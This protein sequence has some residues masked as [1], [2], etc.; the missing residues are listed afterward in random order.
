MDL[1]IKNENAKQLFAKFLP[2]VWLGLFALAVWL[3]G[4][5][6]GGFHLDELDDAL[7]RIGPW[8]L[9][10]ALLLTAASLFCNA[11]LD[12]VALRWLRKDLPTGKVLGT[13]LIAGSFSM[14]GGGTILGGGA[15]RMRFYG[16]FGLGGAEI[17]KITGF[18]MVAGWLGHALLA[19]IMMCWAPPE[20]D[21]L[22]V[23]AGRAIGVALLGTCATICLLSVTGFRGKPVRFLPPWRVMFVA[24][25]V[26]GFDWLFAGLALRVFLPAA[27]S[28]PAFLAATAVGQALGAAS[29]VPGGVGVM[30]LFI[31]KFS[32]GMV[33]QPLMVGAL[34]TYRLTY[35]FI[36]FVIAVAAVSGREIWAKRHWA[37]ITVDSSG[38]AWSAIAP[39]L[40]GMSALAGGFVLM[41][42]A[43][44]PINANRRILL[45]KFVPLPFVETSH[46][47]SSIA[48]T[49]MII[50]AS[51]LLRRVRAA[52]WI[53]VVMA[54]G[55]ILFS[56][57]KGFDWEESIVLFVF[58][59]ALLPFKSKFHR[60]AGI[61]TR[62]FSLHW[63][64][65]I[66]AIVGLAIWFGFYTSRDV[67]YQNQLWWRYSFENDASRLL[68]G[69][70]GSAM[71][72]VFVALLQ[73][74][75]PA[76]PRAREPQPGIDRI[77]EMVLK[78]S[79]CSSALALV[80]DK[81]FLFNHERSA[82]LMY[83]DQGRTRVA[84]ADPVGDEEKFEGLYWRFVEQA[85]DE[86][87]RVAFYQVG[88]AM[89][90]AC[91]EMGLRIYKLGEEAM[92][93][94]DTF[95]LASSELK[96]F[97]KVMNR[98]ERER[99]LFE[100][101][102]P[103]VVAARLGELRAVSDAWLSH[104]SAREKGFSL[105]CFA[106]AYLRRLPVAVIVVEG[107]VIA[108]GNIWP[109]NG[110]DELSTDLM[111]HVPDAPNGVMDCLFVSMMLWGKAQ[112]YRWFDLGMA[113]LSGLTD[114]PFAPLWSRIGG[115][116]YDK[117]EAFYNF[118]GLRAWKSK[119]QP[120]WQPRYLA[121]S[122]AW[123][124][125]TALLDITNLIGKSSGKSLAEDVFS[126][127]PDRD[128]SLPE[129]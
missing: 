129:P 106:D 72:L 69:V 1:P 47:L 21:W 108:F 13:A 99:W 71:I 41:L 80:G 45:E 60:H 8:H 30:E 24:M 117:G 35:Y 52:W 115:L 112:G 103:D 96:K 128:C 127:S 55:G 111:R 110:K 63:W 51:G 27:I 18:L 61:W 26:S 42:S 16:Q 68:R 116:I 114:H 124:L 84:M 86:G 75:R 76:P 57:L 62:R 67:D 81:E 113:P 15:I 107:K 37:K 43:T 65:L 36:P 85:H 32:A 77:T 2:Y 49:V 104:H 3:L 122:K 31:T 14:N 22:S 11:S 4:K 20:L 120:V 23:S 119:F 74:F 93:P 73:Y 126:P 109:G 53:A 6:W 5:E 25:L 95:D 97:R 19:G 88:A 34:L 38:K 17:A 94:L 79:R 100:I 44:T 33:G 98:M 7:R 83:G 12:L 118:N 90:P 89:I 91:V 123:D 46:F 39:R 10:T 92:V 28:T 59:A 82:F 78:T 125:P 87:M 29:H 102:Q 54:A 50:V 58:I 56:M 66:L 64:G 48:G 40:A 9:G 101:W 121:I 70:A 105:G